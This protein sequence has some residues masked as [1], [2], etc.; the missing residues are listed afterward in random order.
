MYVQIDSTKK[1]R[2][3]Y[4]TITMKSKILREQAT[5]LKTYNEFDL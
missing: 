2:D 1:M 3:M 4:T 5:K